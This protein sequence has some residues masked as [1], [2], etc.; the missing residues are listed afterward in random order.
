MD[1]T[2]RQPN[3]CEGM[4]KAGDGRDGP[5]ISGLSDPVIGLSEVALARREQILQDLSRSDGPVLAE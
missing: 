3:P 4:H 2:L 1:E 5:P